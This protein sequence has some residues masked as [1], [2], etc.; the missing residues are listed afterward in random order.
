MHHPVETIIAL[1]VLTTVLAV[2]ARK[3]QVPYPIFLVL[4]GAGLAFIPALPVV[5][6]DPQLVFL[7]FLPPLLYSGGYFTSWRDFRA[8]LVSI[9]LLAVGLVLATTTV[10]AA[11][12]HAIVPGIGWP[13]AF[14][15]GAIVSPPD[16]VAAGAIAK[17]LKLPRRLITI[18][19]GESLVNDS[20]GLVLLKFA[21]VAVVTGAFSL[22]KAAGD[23]VLVSVGGIAVGLAVGWL[24]AKIERYLDDAV[25]A[26][27]ASLLVSFLTYIL[28]ERLSVSG[29]LAVVTAGLVQGRYVPEIWT[30]Q[31]RV[32]GTAV[33]QT[34][35]FV[36]NALIF[37]LIGLQLPTLVRSLTWP[38]STVVD[39]VFATCAAMIGI[40][41]IWMFPGAYLPRFLFPKHR[42]KNPYPPWQMV[43]IAGWTGMRG[44]VSLAAALSLPIVTASGAPFPARDLIIFLT[45]TTILATLVLQGLTLPPLIRWLAVGED[46]TPEREERQARLELA[47]AGIARVDALAEERVLPAHQVHPVRQEFVDRLRNLTRSADAARSDAAPSSDVLHHLRRESIAAQREQ[48]LDLRRR[49]VIGDDVLHRIQHELD[50][51]EMRLSR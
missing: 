50:I 29:V 33:W 25:L 27:T 9:S 31:M 13:S 48:L 16:A 32:E 49:E 37:V 45:F 12:V 42:A 4:A 1:L 39:A 18:L 15:L 6:L 43:V 24:F 11:A 17:R 46:T 41:L 34:V 23:F 38:R 22:G 2:V 8:N 7:F 10:V 35:I 26:T 28:A 14:V 20:T 21:T 5:S 19:E 44:V 3:V 51:E 47:K 40:R 30:A 36:L